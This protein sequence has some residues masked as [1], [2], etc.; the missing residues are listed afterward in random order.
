M[1]ANPDS[2]PS[3][4][5]K[6]QPKCFI[7]EKRQLQAGHDW[8]FPGRDSGN[9]ISISTVER[10]FLRA[11]TKSKINFKATMYSLRHSCATHLHESGTDIRYIQELLGHTDIR[12]SMSYTKL[13]KAKLS[14][15]RS[16]LDDFPLPDEL[17]D[18]EEGRKYRD[19]GVSAHEN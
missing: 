7:L 12:T 14:G 1:Y 16:P 10:I 4:V 6:P 8:L 5:Q 19:K 11:K 13:S 17:D 9:H 2:S 18:G 15:V 3:I